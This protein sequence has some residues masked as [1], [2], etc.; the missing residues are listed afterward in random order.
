MVLIENHY[1]SNSLFSISFHKAPD[2]IQAESKLPF[3]VR[4]TQNPFLQQVPQI[5]GLYFIC[6]FMIAL[7]KYFLPYLVLHAG[8]GLQI[9]LVLSPTLSENT[10]HLSLLR[11]LEIS[12]S[13]DF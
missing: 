6:F 10:C 5:P 7:P 11:L 1:P 9:L 3:S 4:S 13:R 12:Q 8:F 2:A